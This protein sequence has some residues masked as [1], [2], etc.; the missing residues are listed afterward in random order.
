[1]TDLTLTP[2]Q[3]LAIE[4]VGLMQLDENLR[5]GMSQA[6]HLPPFN[7]HPGLFERHLERTLTAFRA[8]RAAFVEI[9]EQTYTEEELRF[10]VKMH[11]EPL[12]KSV[13]EKLPE[14]TANLSGMMSRIMERI[15]T[16]A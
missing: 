15:T 12:W 4:L 2:K 9:T 10:L 5:I 14:F 1:M 3:A 8:E 11:S 13:M 7:E 16:P 6:K